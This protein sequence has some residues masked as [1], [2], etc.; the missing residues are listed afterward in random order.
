VAHFE[1]PDMETSMVVEN[2]AQ[3]CARPCEYTTGAEGANGV[4]PTGTLGELS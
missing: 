3:A 4:F 2:A 1:W